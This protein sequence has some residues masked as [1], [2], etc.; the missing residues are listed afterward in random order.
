MSHLHTY[1]GNY[2]KARQTGWS[3]HTQGVTHDNNNWYFTQW[4]ALWMF[5][6][7]HD[8]NKKIT[9]ADPA[10]G[11]RK[12]GIPDDLM[13][14]GYNHFG[15]F[16]YYGG[17]GGHLFIP[18]YI[19]KNEQ[20]AKKY[21][22]RIAIFWAANL[23]YIDSFPLI[24]INHDD[25]KLTPQI[26]AGWCAVDPRNG[27]ILTSESVISTSSPILTYRI[28]PASLLTG[29]VSGHFVSWTN[30]SKINPL[31]H[32]QGGTFNE[33]GSRLYLIHG[34]WEDCDEHKCGIKVFDTKNGKLIDQSQNGVEPFNYE[35]HGSPIPCQ[36]P[37]GI[38]YWDLDSGRAPGIKGQLHA[39]MIENDAFS[40]DDL[41]F[42]HY[43]TVIN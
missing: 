31:D 24:Y 20:A 43:K 3:N 34:Y 33:N 10:R 30:L 4:D 5:P 39:L 41:Y 7:T 17:Y 28:D 36:E 9:S 18:I 32:M 8:L 19:R 42:K 27:D 2:P 12:V 38:T 26:Q 40:D 25:R 35:F 15:D 14:L 21:G 11:I 22:A 37:E 13:E 23:R 1:L 6:V 29:K 16:D